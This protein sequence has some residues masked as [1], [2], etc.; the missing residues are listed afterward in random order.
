MRSSQAFCIDHILLLLVTRL[1]FLWRVV[2]S[3]MGSLSAWV[4]EA[5]C[6]GVESLCLVRECRELEESLGALRVNLI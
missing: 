4:L 5:L 2:E 1:G 6:D 3:D